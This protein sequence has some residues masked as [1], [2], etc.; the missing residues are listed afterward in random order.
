ML[1]MSSNSHN[2]KKKTALRKSLKRMRMHPLRCASAEFAVLPLGCTP[3]CSRRLPSSQQSEEE[4]ASRYIP[5][6]TFHHAHNRGEMHKCFSPAASCFLRAFACPPPI[7]YVCVCVCAE[8][9][10]LTRQP[11][12]CVLPLTTRTSTKRKL[13]Q[14]HL[15]P[16]SSDTKCNL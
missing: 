13:R 3:F 14:L 15:L 16:P 5:P 11:C 6:I 9:S 10:T 12:K 1:Q 8:T 2:L 7:R 4:I